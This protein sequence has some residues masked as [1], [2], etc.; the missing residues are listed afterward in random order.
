MGAGFK[1][2]TAGAKLPAADVDD[3]LMRQTI[4]VFATTAAR[5]TALSGN[6]EEGM[7]AYITGTDAL[8]Y[9]DGSAWV[10]KERV[11]AGQR[12]GTTDGS[13][14]ITVTLPTAY[15]N[16]TYYVTCTGVGTATR[17]YNVQT[18]QTSSTFTVRVFND[19]G[20]AVTSA[21][22]LFNWIAV[23]TGAL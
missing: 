2:F 17:I 9:Y 8:Y 3:Y 20:A 1:D 18:G 21:S 23:G 5:D 22:V 4:M 10:S 19:A 12:S 16:S 13:G 14:D 15:E 7:H 6:L 11:Q